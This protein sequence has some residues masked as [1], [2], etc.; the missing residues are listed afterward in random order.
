MA[1]KPADRL[2][3][4]IA[5]FALGIAAAVRLRPEKTEPPPPIPPNPQRLVAAVMEEGGLGTEDLRILAAGYVPESQEI[6]VQIGGEDGEG[7]DVILTEGR[8]LAEKIAAGFYLPLDRFERP[9]SQSSAVEKWALPLV[10]AMDVLV[11]NI[12]LLRAA[13][14]DRPPRTRGEF[15]RYARSLKAAGGAYP[16][17]LGLSSGDPRGIQRDIFS[18]IRASGL[19]LVREGKPE[20]GGGRRYT[21]VLEFFS[22]LNGEELLAPGTF[23]S[24]GSDRVGE[25]T[26]GGTAMLIVSSRELREIRGK[27]GADAVGITLVPQADDYIGKPVL[28]LSTWYAGIRADSPHPDEAWTLLR[29]LKDRSALLAEALALV[30]GIGVYGPYISVDPLLDKAWDMYE[31]ADTVEEFLELPGAGELEWALRGELEAMFRRDSPQSPEAAAAAVRR[32][33]EQWERQ[34][35]R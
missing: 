23:V 24:A 1:V 34:S 20:F 3:F 14:F 35:L 21:E 27:M 12:P 29:H 18:W 4:I 16:F 17:A 32:F 7:E 10:S 9:P 26:Q 13:G 31:A 6:S 33:W 2:L 15:L 5:L 28:G 8:F 11:Y 22:L 30:P 19:P 25:F